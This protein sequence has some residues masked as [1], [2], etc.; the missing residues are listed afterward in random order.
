MEMQK[1]I[2]ETLARVLPK[3]ELV[4]TATPGADV[5]QH[6]A[7]PL[8]HELKTVDLE[9]LLPNPRQLKA[10]AALGD[11][12]SFIAY[13]NRHAQANAVV[14]CNFEPKNAKLDFVAVFDEHSH[15]GG[16]AGWRRHRATFSPGMSKEWETWLGSNGSGKTKGQV[17]FAE[18]I[19]ANENDI[20]AVEG[21]PTSLQMHQMATEFVARQ[22]QVLKST[23]R[24]QN[25]GVQLT[26]IADS[27][28]GTTEAMKLFEKFAIGIPVFWQIPKGDEPIAGYRIDARLKY[29]MNQGKVSFFYELIRPDLVHQRAALE[30]IERVRV[31]I[32]AT[33]LLM[34][35]CT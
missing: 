28:A 23:V 15:A 26:Y 6:I 7:V 18:F 32:G 30:L 29:R 20:T 3:A 31:G 25:G 16:P 8:G 17:E 2:A 21:F 1:N 24:L 12:E 10:T 35:S 11:S 27:D 14:W 19:E 13:V 34:G 33:P 22:D 9:H 5:V 4:F